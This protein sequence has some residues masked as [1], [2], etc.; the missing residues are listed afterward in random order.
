LIYRQN[1]THHRVTEMLACAG[2]RL[3]WH[4]MAGV[5]L[6]VVAI[7]VGSNAW[8]P[9]PPASALPLTTLT[10]HHVQDPARFELSG[11]GLPPVSGL[12][13]LLARMERTAVAQG[14]G[15]P[16][17]DYRVSPATV[18]MPVTLEVRVTLEGPYLHIRRFL[19][20]LMLDT[21]TLTLREFRLSRADP[22]SETV[23]ARLSIVVFM[24]PDGATQ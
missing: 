16:R 7:V 24:A 17:A 20:T 23:E 14:L 10:P 22:A 5:L 2:Q 8:T 4:G 13:L 18:E 12:A 19:S 1:I 3:G 6:L 11:V 21:P 9:S 15:W